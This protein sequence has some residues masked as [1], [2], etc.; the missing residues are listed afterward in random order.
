MK[1]DIVLDAATVVGCCVGVGFLSGKEAQLFFGNFVNVAVFAVCFLALNVLV[2]GFCRTHR[3]FDVQSLAKNCFGRCAGIFT[4]LFLL[5][6]FVCVVTML[7]GVESCLQNYAVAKLP[8]YG[9]LVAVVSALILKK[10][11][12][13][14][15]V[16]NVISILLAL[17]YLVSVACIGKNSFTTNAEVSSA[18][19]LKY[20]LFSVT[21]SL[22]V[23]APLSDTTKKSNV[24]ATVLATVALSALIVFL[25]WIADFN[26][27][28]PIFGKTD[29]VFLNVIG[30]VTVILATVT[31]VAANTLPIAQCVG[32]VFQ[33][34]LLCYT[35]I[36]CVALALSM[37]G[38][39]F[40]LAYGYLFVAL[41]GILIT[42]ALTVKTAKQRFANS[43]RALRQRSKNKNLPSR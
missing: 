40:A 37:F 17:A 43:P 25:L 13:A 11:L 29:N 34:D 23:L 31:G 38:F 16:L 28:M 4:A 20:A 39:D 12:G 24:A 42:V 8:M 5:C 32:D 41:V 19:P 21:M 15:K 33:D 3:C 1:K 10:G 30:A 27:D 26:L 18:Q 35:C 22:G 36:F 6:S 9:M 2:R 14:L 7:A